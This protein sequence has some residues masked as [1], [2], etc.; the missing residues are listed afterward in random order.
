VSGKQFRRV[1][2]EWVDSVFKGSYTVDVK[3]GTE[4]YRALLA[5]EPGLRPYAEQLAG[6][7][8]VVWKG[9]AYRFH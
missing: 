2:G 1:N 8:T 3:R 4:Q 9:R 7:V 6:K 5:D